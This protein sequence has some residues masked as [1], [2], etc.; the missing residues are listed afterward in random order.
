VKGKTISL[1]QSKDFKGL[2]KYI[3][4]KRIVNGLGL[5][6]N[7]LIVPRIMRFLSPI[8][9]PTRINGLFEELPP[10]DITDHLPTLFCEV[11]KV[12]PSLVVELGTR[13]GES[14]KALLRAAS[15]AGANMLSVDLSD[16]SKVVDA[17]EFNK[18][19]RFVQAD[20][21]VFAGEF[22]DWCSEN[23]F[24]L[25]IDVLFIDT[26]HQYE[27]TRHEIQAWFPLLSGKGKV[28]FHDTN[29][30]NYFTR[31]DGRILKGWDNQRGVIRAIE[32]TIGRSYDETIPF[33]DWHGGWLIEHHAHSN[34]LTILTRV[35]HGG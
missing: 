33:I 26:S 34:G 10:S 27:H 5:S 25:S 13:G 1:I 11:L 2:V 3:Y 17:S 21:L 14:T 28:I 29:M 35:N 6:L 18:V 7:S 20:D 22:K 32:E 4:R 19:W 31:K 16:C 24:P 9:R 12:A 30:G 23:D 15:I 8:S